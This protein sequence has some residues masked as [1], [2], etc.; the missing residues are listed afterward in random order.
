MTTSRNISDNRA[1]TVV[2][3][4]LTAITVLSWWLAPGHSGGH[5]E[6]SIPITVAA[7]VLGFVKCRLIVRYFME[8]RTAPKWL[9]YSTDAWLVALWVAVLAI[10]LW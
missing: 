4:A 10:Y 8:V 5:A 3:L 2:W 9:R 1:I 7:I 6:A